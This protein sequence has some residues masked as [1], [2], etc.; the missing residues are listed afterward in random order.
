MTR[1]CVGGERRSAEGAAGSEGG[2]NSAAGRA[3][4]V[5]RV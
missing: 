3:G 5:P 2:A 1:V 4:E